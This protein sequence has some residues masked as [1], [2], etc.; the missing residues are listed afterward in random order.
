MITI[1]MEAADKMLSLK[2]IRDFGSGFV[3][4]KFIFTVLIRKAYSSVC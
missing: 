4:E 1:H 2:Q 3:E